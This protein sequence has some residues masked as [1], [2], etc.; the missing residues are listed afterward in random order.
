MKTPYRKLAVSYTQETPIYYQRLADFIIGKPGSMTI[1]A[2]L[3]ARKPVIAIKS[4]GMSPVQRG[5]EEWV[6]EHKVGIIV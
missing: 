1:T 2:A 5:N 3:I 4:R 6:R